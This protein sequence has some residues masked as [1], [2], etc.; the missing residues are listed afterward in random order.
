TRSSTV[1][2]SP[3]QTGNTG[4]AQG[5][6]ALGRSLARA[7]ETAQ[8]AEDYAQSTE[9]RIAEREA[10]RNQMMAGLDIA[11]RFSG[12][13][14]ALA[15]D[16][17]T[18]EREPAPGAQG[19]AEAVRKLLADRRA[20]FIGTLPD[21]EEL[22]ARAESQWD[23]YAARLLVRADG[24][25]AAERVKKQASDYGTLQQN[26]HTLIYNTP[27]PEQFA[28]W[29]AQRDTML[30]GLE[31]GDDDK[32]TLR[33]EDDASAFSS[34]LAGLQDAG[35]YE[36]AEALRK[37]ERFAGIIDYKTS[38]R[39]RALA[40]NGAAVAAREREMAQEIE[41]DKLRKRID[42]VKALV[43]EGA[44]DIRSID[45]GALDSEAQTAGLDPAEVVEV[46]SLSIGVQVNQRFA[47]P[48]KLETA[49]RTMQEQE[50]AGTLDESGQIQLRYMRERFDSLAEETGDQLKDDWRKGGPARL[51]VVRQMYDMPLDRRERVMQA[52][53]GGDSARRAMRLQRAAGMLAIT[54]AEARGADKDLVPTQKL[55]RERY[56]KAF[57]AETAGIFDEIAVAEKQGIID[58]AL[59]IYAGTLQRE[60][61]RGWDEPIFRASVQMAL[62]R[63]RGR[64]GVGS[65]NGQGFLLPDFLS[66]GEY[67][68]RARAFDF[69]GAT[70]PAAEVLRKYTPVMVPDENG[71]AVYQFRDA[72]GAW[73]GKKGGGIYRARIGRKRD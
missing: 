37:D 58:S 7:D 22:R 70:A 65:W 72:T 14:V 57:E 13:Q 60:N 5:V 9:Y 55:D 43:R 29:R 73:L 59:D 15:D 61:K 41:R 4:I 38:Q 6:T 24:F 31:M 47:D 42:G 10:A 68:Q 56:R 54:G 62:G 66:E 28:A 17:A 16:I 53:G 11:S 36:A 34:L 39:F 27:T 52:V 40:E 2:R 3:R 8:A 67:R 18:L 32:A 26:A 1:L 21:D 48:D 33:K 30:D 64:G 49:I 20:K 12:E 71:D 46:Q 19:H 35:Q 50:R 51:Q 69:S 23:S 45:E 25:E 44:T 63:S